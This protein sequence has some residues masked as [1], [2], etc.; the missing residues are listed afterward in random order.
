MGLPAIVILDETM[1]GSPCLSFHICQ[2]VERHFL[3]IAKQD[4]IAEH[5]LIKQLRKK[6]TDA[7]SY[8]Y[9]RYSAALFGVVS[10]IVGDRYIAEEVLQ[11]AFVRMWDRIDHYDES[12]GRLFTWMLNLARNLAIDK[13]RS[14]EM[15]AARKTGGIDNYVHKIDAG[16]PVEQ[17]TD[18]IGLGDLLGKLPEEQRLVIE[19]L[20]LKGYTQS[21]LAE[22]FDMPLGTVKTRVRLA[23]SQLRILLKVN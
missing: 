21:E 2:I 17:A 13:T 22:E 5:E 12:K 10:R 4:T 7:L 16:A 1:G 6:D 18:A 19:Y 20:Y 15:S 3:T 8:L 14:R 23:M 11:D 9:D